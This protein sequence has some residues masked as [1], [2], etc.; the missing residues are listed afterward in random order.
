MGSGASLEGVITH[1]KGERFRE[2]RDSLQAIGFSKEV[3][4]CNYIISHWKFCMNEVF[5]KS[6][7]MQT[8]L[9]IHNC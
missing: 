7:H 2:I 4:P 6:I 8:L 9:F 3:Y 1:D 5:Q